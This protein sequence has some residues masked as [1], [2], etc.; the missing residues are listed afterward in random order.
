MIRFEIEREGGWPASVEALPPRAAEA[1]D[2][3][4]L[5][6]APSGEVSVLFT[7][8]EAV[9]ALNRDWRGKDA[10]T[11]VLSFPAEP[12]PGLPD[13]AQPLGDLALAWETCRAEAAARGVDALDHTTHLLLHGL[14]HLFGYDHRNGA[15][16]RVMEGLEARAMHALGL[17]APY[18][19]EP[20]D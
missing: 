1:L 14:L 4:G 10:P 19:E 7:D 8:D 15:E 11:N 2:A 6:E 13:E 5:A 3:L 16:A 18:E 12:V 20:A 9:R 17:H